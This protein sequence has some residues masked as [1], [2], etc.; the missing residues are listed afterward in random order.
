VA[1]AEAIAKCAMP[2]TRHQP[3]SNARRMRSSQIEGRCARESPDR[4]AQR[5][6]VISRSPIGR[7]VRARSD[8]LF[9]EAR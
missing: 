5:Y 3:Q 9:R 1:K 4:Y 2:A 7:N 8:Q 6:A